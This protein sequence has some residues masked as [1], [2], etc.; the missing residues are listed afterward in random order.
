MKIVQTL[1]DS[2]ILLKRV[3]KKLK[4]KEKNKMEDS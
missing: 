2:D 1:E 3:T 4:M